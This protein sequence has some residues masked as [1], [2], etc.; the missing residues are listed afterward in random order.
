MERINR[1]QKGFQQLATDVL[2]WIT[3]A[4]RPLTTSELQHAIAIEINE[5]ELDEENFTEIEEMVAVCAGLVTVDEQSNIIRLVHYTTQEYFEQTHWLSEA[6]IKITKACVTYLSFD[7]FNTGACRTDKECE[8]RLQKYILYD[9]ASHDWGHHARATSTSIPEVVAFLEKK[10][11]VEASTQGLFVKK[12]GVSDL[13]YSQEFERM[14]GLHLMAYFGVMAIAQLLLDRGADVGAVHK[15]GNT[16]LHWASD[17]GHVEMVQ[18]LLDRGADINIINAYRETPLSWAAK[19]GHV[20][21]AQLLLDRGA[22]IDAVHEDGDTPLHWASDEGHVEMVQL[23]L[24][25]GADINRMNAYREAPLHL[26]ILR[27]NIEIAQLLL[28]RGADINAVDE[29]GDT[30]LHMSSGGGHVEIAQLLLDRGTDINLRNIIED[31]PLH[32]ACYEGHVDIAQLLFDRGAD[33]KA[34]NQKGQTPSLQVSDKG[35]VA[36]LE[37]D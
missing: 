2:S 1:Q 8:E 12:Y 37:D 7:A 4:K 21:V 18:L 36:L 27:Q 35:Q 22:D 25:R 33:I 32:L 19:M 10:A 14:T 17:E 20:E 31:T 13:G 3:Y 6:E 15:D 9:Y 5:P 30:L 23:L 34:V 29:D 11:Q 24:D 28:D 26:A 16:P